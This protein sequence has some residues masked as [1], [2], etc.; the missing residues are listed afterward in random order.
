MSEQAGTATA[1]AGPRAYLEPLRH[2]DFRWL[3]SGQV[4][5]TLGDML[6]VVALPFVVFR[7]GDAGDLAVVLTAFG[8]ARAVG[9]P[10]GGMLAD[11]MD[12][13]TVMLATDIGRAVVVAA[14]VPVAVD[15]QRHGLV[16]LAAGVAVLGLLDGVFL[17]PYWAKIPT[18]LPAEQLAL[19]NAI[20]ESLLVTAVM[21]G[22]FT[23]GLLAAVVSPAAVLVVNAVTFVISALTLLK[24]R[25][26]RATVEDT[27]PTGGGLLAFARGSGLLVTLV[28]MA[29]M[30][31]LTSAGTMNVA[32]PVFVD[33]RHHAG[34]LFGFLLSSHGAGLLAG[35]VAAGLAWRMAGRG[36][37][38]IGLLAGYGLV[39]LAFPYLPG[40]ALQLA[41]T[42]LLGFA[43]G[44]LS[45]LAVTLL[46][47]TTPE[48]LRGRVM[49]LLSAVM[50]GAHPLS[51]TLVG[52]L[53]TG[54]GT[55]AAFLISAIGV[56]AAAVLGVS[57]RSVREA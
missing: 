49:A 33:E 40:T 31:N 8:L 6:L 28:V 39:L 34:S 1:V 11:R 48:A 30:L 32:L 14:L 37:F 7:A 3:V 12:P 18:L 44:V 36:R 19:G 43:A 56:L 50:L 4:L 24:M 26:G 20:G 17:P 2:H 16:F 15:P 53:V 47:Q 9:A 23:G 51:A 52:L 38:A 10:I 13:R 55:T 57:S 27:A 22:T 45:V 29:G 21:V 35:T 54:L 42:F 5:S 41:A 25:G 46:Q